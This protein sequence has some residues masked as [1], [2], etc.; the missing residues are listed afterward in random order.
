MKSTR[1]RVAVGVA[2]VAVI[3]VATFLVFRGSDEQEVEVL[4]GATIPTLQAVDRDDERGEATVRGFL[5]AGISCSDAGNKLMAELGG[6]GEG[7]L[8]AA[9]RKACSQANGTFVV[10]RIGAD[11]E[12]TATADGVKRWRISGD[13]GNL[14]DG[15]T[16]ELSRRSGMWTV[17]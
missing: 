4:V 6:D 10:E 3:L 2:L 15:T 14:P 11:L 12:K 17:G 16:V 1:M 8:R 9:M 13:T 7:R 5:A